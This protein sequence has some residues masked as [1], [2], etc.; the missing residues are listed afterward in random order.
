MS[1]GDWFG[2][3]P[4]PGEPFEISIQLGGDLTVGH[5]LSPPPGPFGL[6]L[7]LYRPRRAARQP[8]W[9][10]PAVTHEGRS[11]TADN[12]SFAA[13]RF[14]ASVDQPPRAASGPAIVH[15]LTQGA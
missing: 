13:S 8:P 11:D 12:V 2:L 6:R 7:E 9:Q 15:Y 5:R 10:P 14:A 3:T 4:A 1:V